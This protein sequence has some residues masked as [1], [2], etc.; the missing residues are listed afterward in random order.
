MRD[1]LTLISP[2]SSSEEAAQ[3]LAQSLTQAMLA[4]GDCPFHLA[5]SGGSTPKRLFEI[6]GISTIGQRLP[7][8][9]LV[10]YWADER[11]VPTDH[12][13]SNHG[14]L[15]SAI[16]GDLPHHELTYHRIHGEDAPRREVLRYA[17]LLRDN[18]PGTPLPQ[19]DWIWLGMGLDG[20][21][22]SLFPE[23]VLEEEPHGIC[24]ISTNPYSGEQR[25]T[26]TEAMIMAAKQVTFL[27]T[28]HAKAEIVQRVLT[29]SAADSVLP[30]ARIT[31]RHS[32]V[33]WLL[34]MEAAST[35]PVGEATPPRHL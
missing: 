32:K 28:G 14:M 7:W 24:G 4:K 6:L 23:S 21:V 3:V 25:I 1:P 5:I 35:L 27:V 16:G 15:M 29:A 31:Y 10:I 11:C 20:H 12:P 34:D 30:A 22:A 8:H 13:D 18:V 26:L 33:D 9:R 17:Q 2:Y 19:L